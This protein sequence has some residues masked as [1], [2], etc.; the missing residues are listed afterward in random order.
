VQS[1]VPHVGL[2]EGGVCSVG[3]VGGDDGFGGR[4]RP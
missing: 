2:V 3:V 4:F 1:W